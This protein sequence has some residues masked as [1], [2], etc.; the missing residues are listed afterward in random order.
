MKQKLHPNQKAILELLKT[1]ESLSY[2]DIAERIGVSSRNTISHHINQLEDKGYLRRNPANPSDFR[3]LKDPADDITYLNLYGMA[4]CGPQGFLA[5]ENVVE[6]IPFSTKAFGVDQNAFLMKARGDSMEPEIYENDLV[7]IIPTQEIIPG[8]PALV[9]H[10][11]M[12][13]IK[14]LIA[15]GNK[16][17]LNSI[18]PNYQDEKI[19]ANDITIVGQVKSIIKFTK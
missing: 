4:Q 11:D 2:Q 9:V 1:G 13:K 10:N 16:I 8:K 18:N 17:I 14:K 7:L 6:R 3:I 5:E 15:S 19:N 12:P